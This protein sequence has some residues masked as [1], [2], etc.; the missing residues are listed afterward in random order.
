MK[1]SKCSEEQVYAL[2]QSETGTAVADVCR[3]IGIS[4]ATL[5]VWKEKYARLGVNEMHQRSRT[6]TAAR[7]DSCRI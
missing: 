4:E 3:H 2:R 5:Y 1:T 7:S 6:R